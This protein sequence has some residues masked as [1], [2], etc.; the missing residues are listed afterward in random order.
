[1]S[2]VEKIVEQARKKRNAPIEDVVGGLKLTFPGDEPVFVLRA[3]DKRAL[4]QVRNYA[5]MEA[6]RTDPNRKHLKNVDEA[7]ESFEEFRRKH[8]ERIKDAD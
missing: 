4:A 8:P 1:L 6:S 5:T 3:K 2:D 7:V